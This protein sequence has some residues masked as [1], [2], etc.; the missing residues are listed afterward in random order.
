MLYHLDEIKVGA[1]VKA[2]LFGDVPIRLVVT[3]VQRDIKNGMPGVSGYNLENPSDT[4]WCYLRQ[5]KE[6][7][8]P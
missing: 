7:M 3:S 5:I 1:V 2:M 8:N 4:R 6:V